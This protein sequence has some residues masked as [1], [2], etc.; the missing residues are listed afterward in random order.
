[1]AYGKMHPVVT[2]KFT[3]QVLLLYLFFL[4]HGNYTYDF[5]LVGGRH[6]YEGRLEVR[7]NNGTWGTVYGNNWSS[8]YASIACKA[9]GLSSIALSPDKTNYFGAGAGLPLHLSVSYCP[10]SALSLF[11][12]QHKVWDYYDEITDYDDTRIGIH[13]LPGKAREPNSAS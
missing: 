2:L 4:A 13:C 11:D 9:L 1:M 3:Y 12:C 10:F 6:E 7:R 8:F 5:R